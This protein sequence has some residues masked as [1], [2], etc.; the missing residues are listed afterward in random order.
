[1]NGCF[2]P[3]L[4]FALALALFADTARTQTLTVDAGPDQVVTSLQ[5]LPRL[6]LE[7]RGSVSPSTASV[8]WEQI[9]G[10]NRP[11]FGQPRSPRT[12]VSFLESGPYALRLNATLGNQSA[13][14]TM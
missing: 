11:S 13:S 3:G 1:M 4:V 2:S 8:S 10:R 5:A 6:R 9:A 14:D 7:L 12:T